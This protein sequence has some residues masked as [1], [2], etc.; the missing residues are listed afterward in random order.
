MIMVIAKFPKI[1]HGR[2]EEFRKWFEW[3]NNLLRET[4]GLISRKLAKD[5]NE[6]YIAIVEFD[7]FDS[8]KTM[9]SSNKH[10]IIH[11]RTSSL[12]SGIPKPEF[13]E[14]INTISGL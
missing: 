7:S 5:R 2:E 6:N 13:F 10:K 3:S 8:F 1:Y 4:P 14:I 9:H 11:E 12:F